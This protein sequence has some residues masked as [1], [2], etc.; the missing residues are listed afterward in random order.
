MW[1]KGTTELRVEELKIEAAQLGEPSGVPDLLGESILQNN[2]EFHLEEEDEIFEGYGRRENAYPYRQYNTYG[3]ELKMTKVKTIVLE[4]QY[5]TATFLPEYGG[6]LW[7]LIDKQT[8]KNLLYTND[9]LQFRNLA[10]RNAWFSGGVEWNI[11]IIGHTPFTTDPLY[12][13]VLSDEEGNP[14]LRMYEYERIRKVFYQMDFWLAEE[15]RYL[16]CRMRIVN[17]NK[18]VVPM[19]WWSNIAVPEFEEGRIIVPAKKAFTN[20]MRNVEKVDIPYVN[21]VDVTRYNNIPKSVDYFFD[22]EEKSPKYIANVDK[23]GF[24]LLQVSTSR[25]RSRKLFTWGHIEASRHWQ[26]FL[27][28]DAGDYI[29][30]QAGLPK[31]QYGCIP[32]APHTAWEWMEQYGPIQLE[33]SQLEK[34]NEENSKILTEQLEQSGR[35]SDLEQKLKDTK[36]LAK[37]QGEILMTGSGYGALTGQKEGTKH[38]E[39]CLEK[40]S[41]KK[42]KAFLGTG[43]LHEPE[44]NNPPDEFWNDEEIFALLKNNMKGKNEK[45]WYAHYQLGIGYCVE[46]DYKKARKEM[47]Q[48]YEL[49]PNPWACHGLSSIYLMNGKK[50]KAVMWILQGLKL[51][52]EDVSYLKEGFKLLHLC[53]AYKEIINCFE[54]LKKEEISRLRFYYISAKYHLGDYEEAKEL[55]EKDGGLEMEDLREGEDS[56]EQ[57]WKQIDKAI[58]GEER[59]VPYKYSFQAF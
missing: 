7:S 44:P 27:T 34:S 13:A 48:S 22:I 37:K 18:E 36:S 10:V 40:E 8:G 6:R 26:E 15:D 42:W 49:R 56:L 30:I 16:N 11:G 25:L 20:T 46:K 52:Q 57:L 59:E 54:V 14:V 55:L 17:E 28:R 5:L 43:I 32:M 1:K 58:R 2:L 50:Q 12:A 53:K 24:G 23:E 19:Y 21:G 41:L 45:N 47:K 39:F 31:T 35:I 3:K 38:L 4:N 29:E 51:E 33:K 9:V